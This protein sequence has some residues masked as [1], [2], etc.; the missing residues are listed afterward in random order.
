MINPSNAKFYALT[1]VDKSKMRKLI[2][3]MITT[4]KNCAHDGSMDSEQILMRQKKEILFNCTGAL[5]R[6]NYSP[7]SGSA[8]D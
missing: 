3:S 7:G 8:T 6:K 2:K 4:R 1:V 5:Q